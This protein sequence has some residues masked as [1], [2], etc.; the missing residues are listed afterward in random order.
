MSA[1]QW[2]FSTDRLIKCLCLHN[3]L[4]TQILFKLVLGSL[5]LVH[6]PSSKNFKGTP[7]S[8]QTFFKP[9]VLAHT[10]VWLQKALLIS[11]TV[12]KAPFFL[13][14]LNNLELFF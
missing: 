7:S 13:S 9:T 12:T 11:P 1:R 2:V 5:I 6:S 4:V 14:R 8:S 10:L 3:S